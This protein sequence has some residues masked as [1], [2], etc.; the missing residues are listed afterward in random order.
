M[1]NIKLIILSILTLAF[2]GCESDDA[3]VAQDLLNTVERGAILR[4]ISIDS[5]V[6]DA[7]DVSS[8][9][10]VT[11]QEQDEKDGKLLESV[12]VFLTFEDRTPA[13]GDNDKA[14]ILFGNI[15]ASSFT[16]DEFKLPR[17]TFKV[18]LAEAMTAFGLTSAEFTGGD[19]VSIRFLLKLTDGRTFTN[20]DVASIVANSSFFKAPFKYF[21]VLNCPF[22]QSTF[23]GNFEVVVDDWED[24]SPGET[25]PL[26]PGDNPDEFKI[27]STN[28]PFVNNPNTSFMI[29]KVDPATATV[30]V[31]SNEPFDYGPN[32]LLPVTG[33][34]SVDT[35][36]GDINVILAFGGFTGNTFKLKKVVN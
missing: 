34:G 2:V 18:T 27:L 22:K 5:P 16:I 12:D 9:F 15:P 28:N 10:S 17:T 35:C 33:K 36:N 4:T 1:K 3:T 6:F 32:L 7:T 14:E 31:T 11:I 20:K 13:N 25:L 8:F 21:A 19:R 29:V 26:V 23:S 24:Y 30:T